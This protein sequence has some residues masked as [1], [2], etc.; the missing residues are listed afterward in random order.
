MRHSRNW[1]STFVSSKMVWAWLE[2]MHNMSMKAFC[3]TSELGMWE[4]WGGGGGG[5]GGGGERTGGVLLH[6]STV[7]PRL[8]EH[9]CPLHLSWL[10]G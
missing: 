10:S 7:D 3:S 2:Y 6:T 1:S 9:L 4:T 5:G 8:S